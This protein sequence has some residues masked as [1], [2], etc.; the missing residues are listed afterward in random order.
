MNLEESISEPFCVK[1]SVL[2]DIFQVD[3]F[4]HFRYYISLFSFILIVLPAYCQYEI[5]VDNGIKLTSKSQKMASGVNIIQ[6][7]KRE[8]MCLMTY[9][10]DNYNEEEQYGKS[11]KV[12]IAL[13]K[14]NLKWPNPHSYKVLAQKSMVIGSRT[15]TSIPYNPMIASDGNLYH[16]IFEGSLDDN[17]RGLISRTFMLKNDC[18]K[19]DN[20]L[21]YIKVLYQGVLYD[22][23][24]NTY[25]MILSDNGY[26][27]VVPNCFV[28]DVNPRKDENGVWHIG[29]GCSPDNYLL[30]LKSNDLKVWEYESIIDVK[31]N[32]TDLYYNGSQRL[33]LIRSG[34]KIIESCSEGSQALINNSVSSRPRFCRIN[35]EIYAVYN[36]KDTTMRVERSTVSFS[37]C[38]D[39][40]VH[41]PSVKLKRN[42]SIHYFE[43][44]EYNGFLFV[45]FSTDATDNYRFS[46]GELQLVRLPL[47][48]FLR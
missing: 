26:A 35:D 47:T 43:T 29:I 3:V 15:I 37:K 19:I 44:I 39:Q 33:Y 11:D 1:R 16:V 36:E 38:T 7:N 25:S 42:E 22:I 48:L 13:Q 12:Y 32:E 6:T 20:E 30:V 27:T 31:G 24:V 46:K 10:A 23:N 41:S 8:N 4:E 14:L 21:D 9:L 5:I 18:I 28:V 2:I 34:N 40:I 45:V 17:P